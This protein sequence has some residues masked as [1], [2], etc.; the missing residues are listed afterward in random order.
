MNECLLSPKGWCLHYNGRN[1]S[2]HY[3]RGNFIAYSSPE[4]LKTPSY[5]QLWVTCLFNDP[6]IIGKTSDWHAP[7][8]PLGRIRHT[9]EKGFRKDETNQFLQET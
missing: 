5:P 8:G 4:D 9:M 3:K 7:S 6:T 2:R 1:E